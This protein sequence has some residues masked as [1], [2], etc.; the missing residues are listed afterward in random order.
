M[1]DKS[2]FVERCQESVECFTTFISE[3]GLSDSVVTV[4]FYPYLGGLIIFVSFFNSY[5]LIRFF[6]ES[7]FISERLRFLSKT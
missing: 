1:N 3:G 7:S 4:S 5:L 2:M 6:F